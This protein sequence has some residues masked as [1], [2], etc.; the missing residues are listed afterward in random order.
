MRENGDDLIHRHSEKPFE[1]LIYGRPRFKILEQGSHRD[2]SSAKDPRPADF[3]VR[4]F[5]LR[6]IEPIQHDGH[7]MLR[8]CSGQVIRIP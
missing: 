1:K 7:D 8:F 2:A 6:A 4:A 3:V 5:D